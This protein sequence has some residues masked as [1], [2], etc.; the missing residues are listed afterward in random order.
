MDKIRFAV[1]G[2][3]RMGR[4]HIAEIK[5]IAGD[6]FELAAVCDHAPDRLEN[7]PAEWGT[8]YRKY[9]SLDELLAVR[10]QYVQ[11]A[12]EQESGRALTGGL[13]VVEV[14]F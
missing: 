12:E 13:R 1:I 7:L 8:S 2:L 10:A 6:R 5:S 14:C 3:G 9:S 4:G 11:R